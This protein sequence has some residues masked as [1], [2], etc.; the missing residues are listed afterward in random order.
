[1]VV[2]DLNGRLA[3][4]VPVTV[5][6]VAGDPTVQAEGIAGVYYGPLVVED[7]GHWLTIDTCTKKKEITL[8][9]LLQLYEKNRNC[10]IVLY[11]K[12]QY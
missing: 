5:S 2:S 7:D 1:M 9:Q 11:K 4:V 6:V 12:N 3:A 10:S 8:Y